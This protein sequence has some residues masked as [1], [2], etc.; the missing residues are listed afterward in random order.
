MNSTFLNLNT[1]DFIKG[2]I[3]AVLSTVITIVYQTVE[4]GSLVFDWKSI[5][6]MALTTAL[7]YIM[8]NLFTNS[9]GKFFGKEN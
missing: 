3:M 4:A 1:T 7:A 6:T 5:G 8:K 9:A 2:L